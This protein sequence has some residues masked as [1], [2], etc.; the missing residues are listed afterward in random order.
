MRATLAN[1]LAKFIGQPLTL[2]VARAICNDV[3]ADRSIDVSQFPVVA[4]GPYSIQCERVADIIEPLAGLH[5]A[6]RTEFAPHLAGQPWPWDELL[7]AERAGSVLM[8]TARTAASE[9]VGMIR[10]RIGARMDAPVLQ[11]IDDLFFVQPEHRAAHPR[12]P[13]ALWRH[14]ERAAFSVGVRQADIRTVGTES[15]AKFLGYRKIAEVW[16]K[17]AHDASDHADIPTR[18]VQEKR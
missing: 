12:L 13:I 2:D 10:V 17:V 14:C 16:S 11:C 3:D 15:I 4:C 9:L 6:Y 8:S 1:A 7:L 18:H 5:D